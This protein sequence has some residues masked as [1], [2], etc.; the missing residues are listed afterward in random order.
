[1]KKI[2]VAV[3]LGLVAVVAAVELIKIHSLPDEIEEFDEYDDEFV[4]EELEAEYGEM[5]DGE[6]ATTS[7]S[8]EE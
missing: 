8:T 1:M 3:G 2:L 6:Y 5:D 7:D 4:D